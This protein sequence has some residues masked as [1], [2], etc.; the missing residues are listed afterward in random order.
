[1]CDFVGLDLCSAKW[2]GVAGIDGLCK[3]CHPLRDSLHMLPVMPRRW[4]TLRSAWIAQL[5][6]QNPEFAPLQ[7][8]VRPKLGQGDG[9]IS[10][11]CK[12]GHPVGDSH[13]M[14]YV[15]P[16]RRRYNRS[17]WIERQPRQSP[18]FATMPSLARGLVRGL[19]A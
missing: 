13:H 2:P 12:L 11:Q 1:M 4:S 9:G 5:S 7:S 6:R 14:L 19:G 3:L 16:R 15:M 17:S 8:V 18:D 10:E